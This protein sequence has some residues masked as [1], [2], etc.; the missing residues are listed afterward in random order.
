MS[1]RCKRQGKSVKD[2]LLKISFNDKLKKPYQYLQYAYLE[3]EAKKD[4]LVIGEEGRARDFYDKLVDK[5]VSVVESA[6]SP[7]ELLEI[8]KIHN[9]AVLFL[10]QLTAV[11]RVYCWF[12]ESD[13]RIVDVFWVSQDDWKPLNTKLCGSMY[14]LA[15]HWRN[16]EISVE[17]RGVESETFDEDG[18]VNSSQR[19][20]QSTSEQ[21]GFSV[22]DAPEKDVFDRV[23]FWREDRGHGILRNESSILSKTAKRTEKFPRNAIEEISEITNE[24]R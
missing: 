19:Y 21:T 10:S 20:L 3:M 7:E 12:I 8:P 18:I 24:I 23:P 9:T 14:E 1:Q 2:S 6:Y 22:G 11:G 4:A 16:S 5:N 15:I 13:G 17:Y